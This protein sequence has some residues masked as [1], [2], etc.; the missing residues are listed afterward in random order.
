MRGD[1]AIQDLYD[2]PGYQIRRL[3]QI[4]AALFA[5]EAAPFGVTSQQY[6]TLAALGEFPQLEQGALCDA[7]HLDRATMAQLLARLEEKGLLARTTAAHDK[8]RKHVALTAR[9]RKTLAAMRPALDHI[10][11]RILAPL[12]PAERSEFA[13]M[14]KTLVDAHA[15]ADATLQHEEAS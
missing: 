13:R 1:M 9:G 14:L 5:A 4:A 11:D 12:P 2:K 8:R 6:T 15:R 7:V 3:R 10:Q